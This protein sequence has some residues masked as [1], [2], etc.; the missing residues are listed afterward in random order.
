MGWGY[1]GPP[2]WES[3][4]C[5]RNCKMFQRSES[6]HYRGFSCATSH[7][8]TCI[9]PKNWPRSQ[10]SQLPDRR[11]ELAGERGPRLCRLESGPFTVPLG[12]TCNRRAQWSVREYGHRELGGRPLDLVIVAIGVHDALRPPKNI[13]NDIHDAFQ[14]LQRL[15]LSSSAQHVIWRTAPF[16]DV[17]E[18][19]GDDK[20]V[21]VRVSFLNDLVVEE[22]PKEVQVITS[23]D[24][25]QPKST[26]NERLRGD[27]MEHFGNIARFVEIQTLMEH[28]VRFKIP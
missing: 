21:N 20:Q 15:V 19:N 9:N 14:G 27:S 23:G 4:Y 5:L 18:G 13:T 28:C 10:H 6:R 8:D 2:V 25:L 22:H 12:P 7:V 24:I 3:V 1:V 17:R 16:R 26:G 11:Q